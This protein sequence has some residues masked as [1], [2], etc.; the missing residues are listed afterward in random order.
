MKYLAHKNQD[1][2]REQLLIEHLQ[3]V[4]VKARNYAS[5]FGEAP[6]GGGWWAYIM[7]LVNILV[8]SKIT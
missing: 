8:S 1:D 4:S 3:G 7:I 5:A 2:G 6:A